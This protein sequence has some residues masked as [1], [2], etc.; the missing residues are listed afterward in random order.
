MKHISVMLQESIDL[1]NIQENGVY[2]DG[3]LGRGGHSKAILET[4]PNLTLICFDKDNEAIEYTKEYLEEY[5]EQVHWIHDSYATMEHHVH[6]LGYEHVSGILLDL[7]V[8]SPQFD[9]EKRGFSYRFDTKL[10]MRMDRRQSLSAYEVVNEYDEDEL[11]AILQNYGEERY[12]RKIVKEIIKHRPVT[13]TFELV[14]CIK[15]AYPGK[16]LRKGHPAKKT[17]QAIRI[18]VNDEFKDLKA[19]LDQAINLLDIK[20]RLVVI[21]FHSLEDKIV[22]QK[23]NEVAKPKKVNPRI[24]IQHEEVLNYR[25]VSKGLKPTDEEI[26]SNNRAR[27]A[28]IRCIERVI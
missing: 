19:V 13:T 15:A 27:S 25:I 8:S 4:K 21:T 7:G 2:V 23:F 20:G 24:P 16:E 17:F 11:V 14:E 18:E 12:A 1:L 28:I 26:D 5:K 10:D 9:D 22:K 3:T 6:E